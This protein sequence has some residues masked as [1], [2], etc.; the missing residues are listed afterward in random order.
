MEPIAVFFLVLLPLV[1]AVLATLTWA[2]Y[3]GWTRILWI[4]GVRIV[5]GGRYWF[6]LS[7][8]LLI[9]CVAVA[10]TMILLRE[11]PETAHLVQDPGHPVSATLVILLWVF[12]LLALAASFWLPEP[13]K[14]GW[15]RDLESK[16]PGGNRTGR[17]REG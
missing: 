2:A 4:R 12:L 10:L 5:V 13:W 14:P 17:R 16:E 15:I 7:P 9:G 11:N 6:V 1:A 8:A 3:S